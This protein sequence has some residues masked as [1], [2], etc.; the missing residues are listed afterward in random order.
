MAARAG[1]VDGEG[2][3]RGTFEEP[4]LRSVDADLQLRGNDFYIDRMLRGEIGI[5]ANDNRVLDDACLVS[6]QRQFQTF[7]FA[8]TKRADFIFQFRASDMR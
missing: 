1:V 8:R 7:A 6:P 4:F 3:S 5:A 2:V